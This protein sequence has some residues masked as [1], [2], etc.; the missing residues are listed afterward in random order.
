MTV[1]DTVTDLNSNNLLD[2][3][4]R[5]SQW[6][7]EPTSGV[8]VV[9]DLVISDADAEAPS[10]LSV[11]FTF[12]EDMDVTRDPLVTFDPAV[13]STWVKAHRKVRGWAMAGPSRSRRQ[14]LMRVLMLTK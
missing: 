1:K 12:D 14:L 3:A 13:A 4:V 8:P 9:S 10:T 6:T 7:H 5:L 11:T 2:Q